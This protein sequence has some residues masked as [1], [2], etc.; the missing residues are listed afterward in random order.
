[1]DN[2][3]DTISSVLG[4]VTTNALGEASVSKQRDD[5]SECGCCQDAMVKLD[6]RWVLEHVAPPH[7]GLVWHVAVEGVEQ[8]LL[9][10]CE[11]NAHPRKVVVDE[12]SIESSDEGSRHGGSE[13]QQ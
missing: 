8:L 1:M 10:R 5:S 4:K 6:K 3:K 13:D 7:I 12:A 2:A 9:W 11:A